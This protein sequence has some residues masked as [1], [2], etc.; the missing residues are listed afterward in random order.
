VP[1]NPVQ[2]EVILASP[3]RAR[4]TGSDATADAEADA[5]PAITYRTTRD[6][7]AVHV[8][9]T[10]E[11]RSLP[12]TSLLRTAITETLAETVEAIRRHSVRLA[13][14]TEHEID[15]VAAHA[16]AEDS[17][18]VAA[19]PIETVDARACLTVRLA[20]GHVTDTEAVAD[21]DAP[22]PAK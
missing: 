2:F 13:V 20:G 4:A 16:S 5:D 10:V 22:A 12:A 17:A 11:M 21:S 9:L 7:V 19:L 3:P 8:E 6:P 14:A 1:K 18:A 15:T